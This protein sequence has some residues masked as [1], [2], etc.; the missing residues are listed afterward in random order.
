MKKT[1]PTAYFYAYDDHT[2]TFTCI[3]AGGR[4][5][6]DYRIVFCGENSQGPPPASGPSPPSPPSSGGVFSEPCTETCTNGGHTPTCCR[7]HG[8]KDGKCNADRKA[9][10]TKQ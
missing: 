8:F 2:S 9:F 4:T 7:A 5:S 3:G 1:C 6:P 10:C